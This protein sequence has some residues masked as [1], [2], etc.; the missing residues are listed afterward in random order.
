MFPGAGI[1]AIYLISG[2]HQ[3]TSIASGLT[4]VA[5]YTIPVLCFVFGWFQGQHFIDKLKY[6]IDYWK[7]W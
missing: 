4:T 5:L 3:I 7:F 1:G 6:H 2:Y